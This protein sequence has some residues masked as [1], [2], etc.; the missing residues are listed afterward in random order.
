MFRSKGRI[1]NL[2]HRIETLVYDL[3]ILSKRVVVLEC[4]HDYEPITAILN[5]YYG[6]SARIFELR[7]KKCKH[8]DR[9]LT[10]AEYHRIKVELAI[11]GFIAHSKEV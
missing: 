4:K 7:C 8:V 9:V 1:K 6:E 2:E 11:G 5:G 3:G 10:E